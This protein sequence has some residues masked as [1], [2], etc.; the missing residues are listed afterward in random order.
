[1]E[2]SK[3]V[4]EAHNIVASLKHTR[5]RRSRPARTSP[6]TFR[7]TRKLKE[8]IDAAAERHNIDRSALVRDALNFRLKQLLSM[9][10]TNGAHPFIQSD[11]EY[12]RERKQERHKLVCYRLEF[13]TI[14]KIAVAKK[15][16]G[17]RFEIQI[18]RPALRDYAEGL[19]K[20]PKLKED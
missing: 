14:A 16:H 20:L 17:V 11:S 5:E 12:T 9:S 8:M 10:P 19:L 13:T 4:F 1:M 6:C 15:H 18:V 7:V 2:H 3:L